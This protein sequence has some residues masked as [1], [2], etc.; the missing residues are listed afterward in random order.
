MS[1]FVGISYSKKQIYIEGYC[2]KKFNIADSFIGYMLSNPTFETVFNI[3]ETGI[4][5]YFFTAQCDNLQNELY[6]HF[7][8]M[9]KIRFS[10][11]SIGS[12]DL[13]A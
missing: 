13:C 1:V 6:I 12:K 2:V 9:R 10:R 4:D 7:H 3:E 8:V 11:I 5:V